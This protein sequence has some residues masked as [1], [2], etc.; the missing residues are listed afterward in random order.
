MHCSTLP[1]NVFESL[2]NNEI[3][4]WDSYNPLT[5]TIGLKTVQKKSYLGCEI[6]PDAKIDKEVDNQLAKVNNAFGILS[7]HVWIYYII[8]KN[9]KVKVY[10]V[11]VLITL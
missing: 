1:L 8:S 5:I 7:K 4:K 6:Y 2:K 11:I 9:M 10:K 3:L